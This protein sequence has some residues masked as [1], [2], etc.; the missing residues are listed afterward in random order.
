MICEK[1]QIQILNVHYHLNNA[2]EFWVGGCYVTVLAI[3]LKSIIHK[4]HL[5]FIY[6]GSPKRGGGWFETR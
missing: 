4:L 6:S 2:L 1:K 5:T 3:V